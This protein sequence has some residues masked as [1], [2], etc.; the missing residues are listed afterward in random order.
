[1]ILK[2]FGGEMEIDWQDAQK[3]IREELNTWSKEALIQFII[4]KDNEVL[5]LEEEFREEITENFKP[6]DW[7]E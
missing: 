6:D 7:E 5:D 3:V 4:D 2:I 1:M